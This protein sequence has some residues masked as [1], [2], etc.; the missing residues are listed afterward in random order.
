MPE[1]LEIIESYD[2]FKEKWLPTES[3]D[4]KTLRFIGNG[5]YGHVYSCK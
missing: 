2:F 1:Y 5:S 3:F 4:Y